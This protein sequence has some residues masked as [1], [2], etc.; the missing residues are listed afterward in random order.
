F[1]D[2][3]VDNIH[4]RIG[5]DVYVFIS[6]TYELGSGLI[7]HVIATTSFAVILWGIS[8]STPLPLFGVD[9]SFPGYLI[10]TAILYAM[11]GTLIA[12]RI[13]L[14]LHER[15]DRISG[16]GDDAGLP[17]GCHS[18]WRADAGDACV[19]ARGSGIR[20]RDPRLRSHRRVEGRH[21]SSGAIR[22]RD[23][24]GRLSRP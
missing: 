14:W 22:G 3:N 15:L 23:A 16:A 17:D 24:D 12:H 10:V 13:H 8:A 18:A 9:V 2:Q 6:K 20:V 4:L 5:N 21:G 19:P 11:L 1:V 7:G